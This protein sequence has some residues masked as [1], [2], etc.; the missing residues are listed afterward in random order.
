[1]A[2]AGTINGYSSVCISSTIQL[3]DAAYGGVWSSLHPA[4]AVVNP[5]NGM[6]TGISEGSDTIFYTV[7]RYCSAETAIFPL[8]VG[9]EVTLNE[10]TGNNT[11][12]QYGI[13]TLRDASL[14]GI[15][16]STNPAKATIDPSTGVMSAV[17]SGLDTVVYTIFSGCAA[18]VRASVIIDELP[19][20]PYITV[21]PGSTVCANTQYMNIGAG[22]PQP[23]TYIY[24]WAAFNADINSISA[25]KQNVLVSFPTAG[26]AV[27]TLTTQLM[28]TGC[29]MTDSFVTNVGSAESPTAGITYSAP[30]FTCTDNTADSYQWGYDNGYTLD[31]TIIPGET[32]QTYNQP[33]PDFTHVFY[34]VMTNHG[35]CLQKAYY[36]TPPA[37]EVGYTSIENMQFILFPNPANS[38][39][40]IKVKGMNNSS[41]VSVQLYDLLGNEISG[42]ALLDGNGS[43]DVSGLAQGVYSVVLVKDGMKMGARMFVKN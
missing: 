31:S 29:S 28:I 39:V 23:V 5:S 8:T 7:T 16:T 2:V 17:G 27:V 13:D 20:N 24:T 12:C 30:T 15:W 32:S 22:I 25:N 34:W 14:G 38:T 11:V 21:H 35:G 4:V 41:E 3:T 9:P 40:N 19:T 6:V 1:M 36:K 33:A 43:I 18:V 37:V 26:P 42:S 10:I